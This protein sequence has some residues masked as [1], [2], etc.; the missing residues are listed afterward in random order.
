MAE[1]LQASSGGGMGEWQQYE[2]ADWVQQGVLSAGKMHTDTS[3]G[4]L[5]S[6]KGIPIPMTGSK[7][8]SR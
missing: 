5:N 6:G 2:D 1:R 8:E 4:S 7:N 3:R